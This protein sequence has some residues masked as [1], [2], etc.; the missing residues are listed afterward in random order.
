MQ[1]IIAITITFLIFLL[2][3]KMFENNWSKKLSINVSFKENC[4]QKGQ[5]GHLVQV[6]NNAKKMPLP[7]FNVKFATSRH[8]KFDGKDHSS[9]TDYYYRNEA[10]SVGGRRKITRRLSFTARKRGYFKI[11]DIDVIARDYF[12]T[13]FFVKKYQNK[14]DIYVFPD[15]LNLNSLDITYNKI[16]GDIEIKNNLLEDPYTFRGIREYSVNDNMKKINWKASAKTGNLMVNLYGNTA[17]QKLKILV[18][19]DILQL[20]KAEELQE[21]S[22]DLASTAAL[23]FLMRNIPVSICVNGEDCVTR[24]TGRVDSGSSISHLSTID[25]YLARIDEKR[26][27]DFCK[28]LTEELDGAGTDTTF[29]VISAS[30]N[31][32]IVDLLD[33]INTGSVTMIVPGL[34]SHI[35]NLEKDYM[36]LIMMDTE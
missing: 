4:I 20:E 1:L 26:P 7:V 14:T 29:L 34:T 24:N 5:T 15:K 28:L 33:G 27:F 9:V 16:L 19:I 21:F 36:N 13:R 2:Q 8:L 12:L 11:E 6:I 3:R 23:K 25:R 32:E 17:E 31:K 22:M 10:F 35:Y 30:M 18:N